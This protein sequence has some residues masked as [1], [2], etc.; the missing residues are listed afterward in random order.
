VL[1]EHLATFLNHA[2]ESHDGAGIPRFVEKELRAFLKCGVL[3]HGLCRFRCTGCSFERLVPLSCK[4]RGFC[5]SCGGRRMTELSAHLT[6]H[7]VPFVPVRQ[8]VLSFPHRL[9]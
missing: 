9:R 6:D 8:F 2:A 5:P 3:A 1:L 4:G 7:V